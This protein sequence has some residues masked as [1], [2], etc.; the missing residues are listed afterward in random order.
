MSLSPVLPRSISVGFLI[1][2]KATNVHRTNCGVGCHNSEGSRHNECISNASRS[3]AYMAENEA[4]QQ[5]DGAVKRRNAMASTARHPS[6]VIPKCASTGSLHGKSVR[7]ERTPNPTAP[8]AVQQR[9]A[10]G[11]RSVR[12]PLAGTGS[13]EFNYSPTYLT[14]LAGQQQNTAYS[15]L[16][17]LFPS[18]VALGA[19]K[20]EGVEEE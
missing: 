3:T 4:R 12:W 9:Q 20:H 18:A 14:L 6:P 7:M 19:K 16:H 15:V 11:R 8:Y 1:P 5:K 17:L 2:R 13:K 10:V